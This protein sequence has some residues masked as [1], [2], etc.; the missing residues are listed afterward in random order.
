MRKGQ[1]ISGVKRMEHLFAHGKSFISYPLRVVYVVRS[2]RDD[3]PI[4]V[5]VSVPKKKLKSAVARNRMKRLVREAFRQNSHLLDIA[6]FPHEQSLD[7]AFVYLKDELCDYATIQ[8]AVLK[9][10]SEIARCMKGNEKC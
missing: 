8:K 2:S 3:Y 10:L 1:R 9:A 6:T 4:S 5:M 7:I